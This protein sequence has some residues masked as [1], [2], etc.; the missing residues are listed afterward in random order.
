MRWVRRPGRREARDSGRSKAADFVWERYVLF[1]GLLRTI[2][3]EG[4]ESAGVHRSQDFRNAFS[5][6]GGDR[7]RHFSLAAVQNVMRK[8]R[9]NDRLS[10]YLA[11][12]IRLLGPWRGCRD[13]MPL[14][15]FAGA[16]VG[17]CRFR[18]AFLARRGLLHWRMHFEE[19]AGQNL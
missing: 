3:F 7:D 9:T 1:G 15:K 6:G 11:D 18:P 17:A 8:G 4:A 14:R 10:M 5:E 19:A 12:I 13:F 16:A 2:L